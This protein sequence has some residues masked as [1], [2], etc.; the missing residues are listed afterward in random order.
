M[1]IRTDIRAGMTFQDCDRIRNYWKQQS[2]LM[3]QYSKTCIQPHGLFLPPAVYN[4]EPGIQ[5]TPP[6][7]PVPPTPPMPGPVTSGCGWVNGI[8]YADRSG[9]CG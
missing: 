9:V 4:N 2:A 6:T 8:Y 1:K 5:P 3:Q 7:P